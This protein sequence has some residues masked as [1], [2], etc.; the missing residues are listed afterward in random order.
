MKLRKGTHPNTPPRSVP[1]TCQMFLEH[2]ILMDNH[3]RRWKW[4]QVNPH[5]QGIIA[6]QF[7]PGKQVTWI[8]LSGW[9]HFVAACSVAASVV[10]FGVFFHFMCC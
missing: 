1:G 8:Y 6:T 10:F 3:L 2:I 9:G 7:T 5:V 4:W